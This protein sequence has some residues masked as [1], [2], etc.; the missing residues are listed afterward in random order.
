LATTTGDAYEL[1]ASFATTGATA[2]SVSFALHRRTDGSRDATVTYDLARQLLTVDNTA[3]TTHPTFTTALAPVGGTLSLEILVDRGQLE[4]FGGG[5]RAVISD[6]VDFS[7]APGNRGM[8]LTASGGAV[9]LNSLSFSTLDSAWHSSPEG[10]SPGN[11]IVAALAQVARSQPTDPETMKCVDNDGPTGTVQIWDC[12]GGSNQSW[13]LG[14][15]GSLVVNGL[16]MQTPPGQT[17]NHTTVQTATC[18]GGGNQK[19]SRGD[20]GSIVNQLSGRCL[21]VDYSDYTNGRPLQIYDCVGSPNQAWVGPTVSFPP[22]GAIFWDD[23][24]KCLDRDVASGR[25][26]IWDCL[27]NGNQTWTLNADGTITTAGVCLEAPAGQTANLT[28]VDVAA[29]T[30]GSNQLWNRSANQALRNSA[31]GRCLDLPYGDTTN[32]RQLQLYDCVGG[33]NQYWN[34]PM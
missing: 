13:L 21:D 20:H 19:W 33:A 3:A 26:Q 5:G 29:C 22:A 9:Q 6:N 12:T 8:S 34:P 32:G 10:Q 16:C 28:L 24:S 15:D 17:A 30:G 25:A 31:S 2:Q 14:A 18:S 4:V 7:S 23:S 11:A 27:G 1:H